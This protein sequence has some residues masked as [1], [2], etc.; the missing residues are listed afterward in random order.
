MDFKEPKDA[1]AKKKVR[2]RPFPKGKSGNPEGERK[3]TRNA[4]TLAA[5][6]L[7]EGES[8]ALTWK[9]VAM[10]HKERG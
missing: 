7:L 10:A 6:A 5:E 3:G 2:G 4:A 8:K 1:K 9:L